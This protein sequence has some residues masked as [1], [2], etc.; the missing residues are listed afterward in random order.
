ML[1]NKDFVDL[2]SQP[3]KVRFD[4]KQISTWDKQNEAKYKKK[5]SNQKAS[6]SPRPGHE[7]DTEKEDKAEKYRDRA[8]E[9]RKDV[10]DETQMQMDDIVQKL[11]AEQTKYLGGDIEH[12]HLV[13]GLDYALLRKVRDETQTVR[14]DP[15]IELGFQKH[16]NKKNVLKERPKLI[17]TTQIGMNLSKLL[18]SNDEVIDE[19]KAGLAKGPS[20]QKNTVAT[21]KPGILLSKM[22][23]EFDT[24]IESELELPVTISTSRKVSKYAN[25]IWR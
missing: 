17:T 9:R 6:K 14:T 12:T 22:H 24:S 4:L 1:S 18:F 2:L 13:K 23:Y 21:V 20:K 10:K 8:L 16:E 15:Q 19:S 25:E 7:E 3:E 5:G 11:D